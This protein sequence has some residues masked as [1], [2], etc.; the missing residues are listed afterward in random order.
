[1]MWNKSY[2]NTEMSL[3]ITLHGLITNASEAATNAAII[4]NQYFK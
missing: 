2:T 4:S 1:M 3:I